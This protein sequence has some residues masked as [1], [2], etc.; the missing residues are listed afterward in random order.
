MNFELLP[1]RTLAGLISLR[2]T[3]I[4]SNVSLVQ[5]N[6]CHSMANRY[7]A[8]VRDHCQQSNLQHIHPLLL[9][10][11][12]WEPDNPLEIG[13]S[14]SPPRDLTLKDIPVQIILPLITI[15]MQNWPS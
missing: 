7:G 3:T 14:Q 8:A 5:S 6:L 10:L 15:Y 13:K 4:S 2:H 1:L 12:L 11:P 9:Y